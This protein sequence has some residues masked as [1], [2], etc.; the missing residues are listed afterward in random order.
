VF[1]KHV[2]GRH[3]RGLVHVLWAVE[4]FSFSND[5]GV[6]FLTGGTPGASRAALDDQVGSQIDFF[7]TFNCPRGVFWRPCGLFG[8]ALG[9]PLASLWRQKLAEEIQKESF[10]CTLHSRALAEGEKGRARTRRMKLKRNR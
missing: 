4:K 1:A 6:N 10:W 5:F 7:V 2:E 8:P 3:S 9:R